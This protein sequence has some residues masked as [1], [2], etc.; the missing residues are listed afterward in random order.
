VSFSPEIL[1]AIAEGRRLREKGADK[2][3][4][5]TE[6]FR[7]ISTEKRSLVIAALIQ[8]ADCTENGAA[9]YYQ[10]LRKEAT[11]PTQRLDEEAKSPYAETSVIKPAS[12]KLL[13]LIFIGI[14]MGVAGYVFIGFNDPAVSPVSSQQLPPKQ[15]ESSKAGDAVNPATV[16]SICTELGDCLR[17]LFAAAGREDVATLRV[18]TSQMSSLP[19]PERGNR[20]AARRY[21]ADGLFFFQSGDLEAAI[22]NFV[23]GY[24]QD[25]LDVELA[26]NLGMALAR[27]GRA[28]EAV[29]VLRE[30][31]V[32]DPR[33]IY[34]WT[35]LGEALAIMGRRDEA[36]AALWIGLQWSDDRDRAIA[37]YAKNAE[38]GESVPAIVD[39]Y[40]AMLSWAKGESKPVLKS[41][42]TLR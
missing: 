5:S 35:P 24:A 21:N 40:K 31:L 13:L 22:A 36:L 39:L 14:I 37:F 8:G 28:S 11:V 18:L 34:T 16:N 33:R 1:E 30:A 10:R 19:K 15:A 29:D 26:A 6:I 38:K 4:V 42:P 27:A 12:T 2:W 9:T 41:L 3:Q 17:Q 32:I 23:Q 20:Q 25:P 7:R